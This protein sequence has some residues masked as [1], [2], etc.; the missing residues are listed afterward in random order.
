VPFSKNVKIDDVLLKLHINLRLLKFIE[1]VIGRV[2]N[3]LSVE[4]PFQG[5]GR[6][7]HIA[8]NNAHGAMN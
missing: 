3:E 2:K 8:Y 6:Q 7:L 4:E 1:T 5:Y